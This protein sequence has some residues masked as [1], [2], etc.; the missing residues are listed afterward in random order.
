MASVICILCNE[1]TE[2]PIYLT[3][4]GAESINRCSVIRKNEI[5]A[6]AESPVHAECRKGY[7]NNKVIQS[8]KKKSLNSSSEN[9]VSKTKRPRLRTEERHNICIFCSQ[10]VDFEPSS[11]GGEIDA[12]KLSFM[13]LRNLFLLAANL[14]VMHGPTM[15]REK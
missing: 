10:I 2:T 5:V 11:H 1:V 4:K 14:E 8:L 7:T 3:P 13:N 6:T 9:D 15:F 12:S